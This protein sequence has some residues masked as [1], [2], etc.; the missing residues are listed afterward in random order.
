MTNGTVSYSYA[1]GKHERKW[2]N[3]KES[4][5]ESIAAI[6]QRRGSGIQVSAGSALPKSKGGA[7]AADGVPNKHTRESS[8]R[9][10]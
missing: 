7:E 6:Y 2:T 10:T 1:A 5:S 9:V 3:L 4:N 8:R